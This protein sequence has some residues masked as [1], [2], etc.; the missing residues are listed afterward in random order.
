MD[1]KGR[2]LQGR[3]D[4]FEHNV[5]VLQTG[6]KAVLKSHEGGSPLQPDRHGWGVLESAPLVVL[7]RRCADGVH[8]NLELSKKIR[9]IAAQVIV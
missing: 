5:K 1:E 4:F 9:E 8:A 7:G 6:L 3:L 2:A